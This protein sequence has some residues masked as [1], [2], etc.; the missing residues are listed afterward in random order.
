[1][2]A[3]IWS[4][5]LL[6]P[7]KGR[8]FCHTARSRRR[9]SAPFTAKNGQL[10]IDDLYVFPGERGTVFVMDVNSDI[11]GVY[12]QPGFHPEARYEFKIHFGRDDFETLAYRVSFGDPT[13]TAGRACGCT[14]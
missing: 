3:A 9:I 12:A 11:T 4:R 8:P 10:F 6:A 7:V 1:V 13:R 2:R 14:R 5:S